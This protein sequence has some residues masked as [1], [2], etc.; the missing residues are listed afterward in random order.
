MRSRGRL[1]AVW[2]RAAKADG[3]SLTEMIIVLAILL[4]VVTALTQLFVSGSKAEVDMSNRVQ[5]QQN[6]RLALDKL[7]REIHCAKAVSWTPPFPTSSITITLGSYCTNTT[8][9]DTTVSWCTAGSGGRFK[10]FRYSGSCGSGTGQKWADYL[11]N[12][13]V[14]TNYSP[15]G[16]GLLGTLRIELPVDLTPG[17]AKQRYKLEDDIVLRNTQR[18]P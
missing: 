5:A 18:L 8:G 11:T 14:F 7:R 9:P 13:N 15:P 16:G 12:G 3:Y 4:V 1:T 10:L 6:A 2:R 17:D